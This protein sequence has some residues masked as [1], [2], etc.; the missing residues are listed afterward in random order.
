MQATRAFLGR[1]AFAAALSAVMWSST[2]APA[3][4]LFFGPGWFGGG[5]GPPPVEPG[6]VLP[7]R[8]VARILH[9]QGFRLTDY[10]ALRGPRIYALAVDNYGRLSSVV[11]DAFSG[12]ILRVAPVA[13]N[14]Y[15]YGGPGAVDGAPA[16]V[17]APIAPAKP[18]PRVRTAARPPVIPLPGAAPA[19]P[20]S[21]PSQ[22]SRPPVLVTPAAPPPTTATAPTTP[23]V[24]A[25]PA[26]AAL[27]PRPAPDAQPADIGP[28]V[29]P[30]KPTGEA[31]ASPPP[32]DYDTEA[33]PRAGT[34][35]PEEANRMAP[36]QHK[37]E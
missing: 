6:G 35:T 11:L 26:N 12:S 7:L 2:A 25:P 28:K 30:V 17:D 20:A 5:Y 36:E 4:A 14:A 31:K 10:P 19:T 1:A 37:D 33:A 16:D 24:A 9:S 27:P 21:P 32:A 15:A 29:V 22:A 3:S 18:K 8:V 13:R 34:V 23:A